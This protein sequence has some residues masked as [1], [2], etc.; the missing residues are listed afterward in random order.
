MLIIKLVCVFLVVTSIAGANFTAEL[1]LL[2]PMLACSLKGGG[3]LRSFNVTADEKNQ[4]WQALF[5]AKEESNVVDFNLSV[6]QKAAKQGY[7]FA[8]AWESGHA[9]LYGKYSFS[10]GKSSWSPKV[11]TDF[12]PY[13]D[14]QLQYEYLLNGGKWQFKWKKRINQTT[15][16]TQLAF[17]MHPTLNCGLLFTT[18]EADFEINLSFS[19]KGITKGTTKIGFRQDLYQGYLKVDLEKNNQSSVTMQLTLAGLKITAKAKNNENQLSFGSTVPLK[20]FLLLPSL[21]LN[22]KGLLLGFKIKIA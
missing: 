14:A 5:R 21:T 1:D 6:W 18:K 8:F 16:S 19:D 9:T 2:K 10:E 20:E 17:Y 13:F 4:S 22:N 7:D 11:V 3:Y 12:N 15:F